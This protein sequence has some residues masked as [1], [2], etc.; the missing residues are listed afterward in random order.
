MFQT[1]LFPVDSSRES[2]E[3]AAL[4][5]KIVQQHSSRLVILSVVEAAGAAA[6][7]SE[8]ESG[9]G[10]VMASAAAVAELLDNAK[11]LFSA[12][13][14]TAETLERT[15]KPAFTICD[16]ADE[17]GANLIAM[18]TRGLGLTDEGAADSVTNRVISLSPCPVM[19]IP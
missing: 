15:G 9:S 10:A 14:I 4:V 1:I 19:V 6:P 16:V 18:G 5:A 13:G 3:A 17:I 7:G 2:R 8:P 12:Q 11:A